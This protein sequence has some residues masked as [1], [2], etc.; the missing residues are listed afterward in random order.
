[1]RAKASNSNSN[2]APSENVHNDNK[3][4]SKPL[5]SAHSSI[6]LMS[7]NED[8][9]IG[10]SESSQ[11][12]SNSIS[13]SIM[14]TNDSNITNTNNNVI[15]GTSKSSSKP[16]LSALL[17]NSTDAQFPDNCDNATN[18]WAKYLSNFHL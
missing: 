9:N 7:V 1:M 14:D 17:E 16:N 8:S 4:N 11:D 15:N 5:S 12:G 10:F 18:N 6:S 13:Q 3:E 2:V